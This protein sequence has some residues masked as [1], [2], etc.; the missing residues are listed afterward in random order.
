MLNSPIKSIY[1]EFCKGY[2]KQRKEV[3]YK[4]FQRK[5]IGEDEGVLKFS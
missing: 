3:M 5:G 4:N 1:R 2:L